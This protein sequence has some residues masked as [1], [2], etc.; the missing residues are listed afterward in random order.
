MPPGDEIKAMEGRPAVPCTSCDGSGVLIEVNSATAEAKLCECVRHCPLCKDA[1]FVFSRDDARREVVR[2][3]V[4]RQRRM[5]VRMYN[6][7][8]VPGK[9]ADAR[10]EPEYCNRENKTTFESL[11]VLS[12]QY[13]RG[14]KGI[15]LMGGPGVGKTFLVAAFIHKLIFLRG[16]PV[17]FRDFFHLLA[18]IRSGYSMN[19]PESE[20]I[21]PLVDVEVLVIDELGKGR[22]T[23]FEQN[24]LDVLISQRYNDRKMTIFTTNYTDDKRTTLAERV[25][26]KD[27]VPGEG[28]VETRDTLRDRVGPRIYSRL[29]EM[30]DFE[31]MAGKDRRELEY[32][33]S[34]A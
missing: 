32:Q 7:A 33:S 34:S 14:H 16:V 30:C 21:Q 19:R 12:T 9:F 20:L 5:R 25:R 26:P 13:E 15:L 22:N 1:G 28:D 4:C 27:A 11:N 8:G 10:L 3:C 17:H 18:E 29:Q 23:P 31:M 24:I 6:E 2:E